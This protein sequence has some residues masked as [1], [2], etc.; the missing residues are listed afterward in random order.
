MGREGLGSF[1]LHGAHT[2]LSPQ[3]RLYDREVAEHDRVLLM[4]TDVSITLRRFGIALGAVLAVVIAFWIR[5]PPRYLTNDDVTIR[6]ALEGNAVPGEAAT[7][8]VLMTHAVLGWALVWL[9]PL[10]PMA[11]LWDLVVAALLFCS[12]AV[13]FALAWPALGT[14]WLARLTALGT[15]LLAVAPLVVDVQFTISATLAGGASMLLA[16]IEIASARPRTRVIISSAA[17]F[18]G[19]L[20]VRPMG[21]AAGAVTVGLFMA[22]WA[23]WQ[24]GVRNRLLAQMA[25]PLAVALVLS[26]G[27]IYLDGLFYQTSREWDAYN[28]Y[29]WMAAQL[30]EWGGELPA[31]DI[32]AIR[33]AAGWSAN[34]WAMMQRWSSVD[35]AVHG[36]ER[37]SRAYQARL[38]G[39][40]WANSI[41]SIAHRAAETAIGTTE[42]VGAESASLLLVI[43]GVAAVYGRWRGSAAVA[44]G[45]L[46]FLAECIAIEAGFKDLPFRLLA[47]LQTGVV[48]AALAIVSSRGREAT[49]GAAIIVLAAILTM[50]TFQARSVLTSAAR[51]RLHTAQ[52]EQE[53]LELDRLSPSI[54]VMH[55]DA[56]PAEH[57]WRPFVQPR[58]R[59]A[60]IPLVG[61]N[62]PLLQHFLTVTGR[63]PLFRAICDDPS[64]L[65]VSEEDR[66]DLLTTYLREHFKRTIEWTQVYGGSFRAWRCVG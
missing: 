12:L 31:A 45:V 17:L 58:V 59:L 29:N 2:T 38:S 19:G 20:L 61:G 24:S 36:F 44:I 22:G 7:G 55:A 63:Q 64:I 39:M 9:Q 21:A 52:V 3:W 41:R 18:L 10:V 23:V 27:L 30:T 53:V 15:L 14:Q 32:L 54:I 6:L 56:F 5:Y 51:D 47:P 35:P 50:L 11:P 49:V 28:R 40:S 62:N 42:H 43:L 1:L 46:I 4:T 33:A 57:W 16:V 65:V 26:T 48:A 60:A 34:D 13:L 25:I 8:F 66:L 37:V